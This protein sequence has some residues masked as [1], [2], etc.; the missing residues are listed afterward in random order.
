MTEEQMTEICNLMAQS[1]TKELGLR[2]GH[3]SQGPRAYRRPY[4]QTPGKHDF[5]VDLPTGANGDIKAR[6]FAG[7]HTSTVSVYG[8]DFREMREKIRAR[9]CET[10]NLAIDRFEVPNTNPQGGQ[11]VWCRF[12]HRGGKNWSG[13]PKQEVQ[14]LKAFLE[15]LM[16]VIA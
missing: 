10:A 9:Q 12:K 13:D 16:A 4:Y 1:I 15:W 3:R 8:T 7:Y 2:C 5:F 6:L 11:A 14:T